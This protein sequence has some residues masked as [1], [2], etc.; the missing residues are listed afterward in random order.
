MLS[1]KLKE[2]SGKK[3]FECDIGSASRLDN[4]RVQS[5]FGCG[6]GSHLI[7]VAVSPNP[8]NLNAPQTL[9]LQAIGT[10]SDGTN[11]SVASGNLDFLVSIACGHNR[12]RGS[13]ELSG[14]ERTGVYGRHGCCV[15]CP[16]VGTRRYLL[17]WTRRLTGSKLR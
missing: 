2:V 5:G 11:E 10:Y 4:V 14:I 13:G 17:Q 16:V 9:Q 12:R 15:F 3:P 1:R 8:A 7:S 6:T